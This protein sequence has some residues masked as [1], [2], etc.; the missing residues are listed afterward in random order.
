MPTLASYYF[1]QSQHTPDVRYIV[2]YLQAHT[3]GRMDE[4]WWWR[5]QAVYLANHKLKNKEWALELAKPLINTKD[6]PPWV[7]QLAAFIYEDM[8]EFSAA[9]EIMNHVSENTDNL[10]QG[11]L[12]FI[13]YFI[14][15]RIGALKE[16][17]QQKHDSVFLPDG[18]L[19]P[20]TSR[21][22]APAEHQGG[23]LFPYDH[24]SPTISEQEK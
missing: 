21:Y 13:R 18:S 16:V 22:F 9:L 7:N 3:E 2:E 4:K 19:R 12:N 10:T 5:T 14:D 6:V 20:S 24:Q 15:E 1:S 17:E 8:G 11:E 23:T